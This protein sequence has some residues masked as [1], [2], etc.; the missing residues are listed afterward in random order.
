MAAVEEREHSAVA[1]AAG[2]VVSGR[3]TGPT[4]GLA[5]AGA[6]GA[7]VLAV[8]AGR[9]KRPWSLFQQGFRSG[10]LL[11]RSARLSCRAASPRRPCAAVCS[12]STGKR[13]HQPRPRGMGVGN[14]VLGDRCLLSC[15]GPSRRCKQERARPS[16]PLNA[17]GPGA[18]EGSSCSPTPP[19][20]RAGVA[21]GAKEDLPGQL[22]FDIGGM[23]AADPER[24]PFADPPGG[25][26]LKGTG[27][28]A[29]GAVAWVAIVGSAGPRQQ[30]GGPGQGRFSASVRSACAAPQR[31]AAQ[32]AGLAQP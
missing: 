21:A 18:L 30:G 26:K 17:L 31:A 5:K 1:G 6:G 11:L 16:P 13:F 24:D 10:L 12:R 29:G 4:S 32:Q 27:S 3:S 22:R 7:A 8:I 23:G 2:I 15:S 14:A 19:G 9:R 28:G 25:W 20:R